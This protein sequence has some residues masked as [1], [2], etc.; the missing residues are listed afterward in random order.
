MKLKTCQVA[1]M[2]ASTTSLADS[3]R[4]IGY[5]NELCLM[6]SLLKINYKWKEY[7]TIMMK[8]VMLCRLRRAV[9][10]EDNIISLIVS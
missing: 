4:F 10:G 1:L 5:A 6:L 9:R 3:L 2:A 7:I 8:S